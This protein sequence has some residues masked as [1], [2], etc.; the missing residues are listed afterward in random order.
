MMTTFAAPKLTSDEV[1]CRVSSLEDVDQM[2]E[3]ILNTFMKSEPLNVSIDKQQMRKVFLPLKCTGTIK[4]YFPILIFMKKKNINLC[5]LKYI[6]K[7]CARGISK[8]GRDAHFTYRLSKSS[9]CQCLT[10]K[11]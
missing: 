9:T 1:E 3:L 2:V 6:L 4:R 5:Q 7:L 10:E 8:P 11:E